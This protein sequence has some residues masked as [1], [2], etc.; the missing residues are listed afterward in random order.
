MTLAER[1]TAESRRRHD[2]APCR[3]MR[4]DTCAHCAALARTA[5][6]RWSARDETGRLTA[7]A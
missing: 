5:P 2:A 4:P 7:A 3:P 1:I 6:R